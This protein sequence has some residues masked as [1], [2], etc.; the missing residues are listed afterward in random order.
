MRRP[1]AERAPEHVSPGEVESMQSTID[2]LAR[3]DN[4]SS[5]L[6]RRARPEVRLGVLRDRATAV[7]RA[8]SADLEGLADET[9]LLAV[10]PGKWLR[11]FCRRWVLINRRRAA[12]IAEEPG[13]PL[14][15]VPHDPAYEQLRASVCEEFD[16]V[17][18][19]RAFER[20]AHERDGCPLYSDCL[21]RAAARNAACLPC[22]R[23]GCVME[24]R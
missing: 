24:G 23:K 11:E 5:R 8:V 15:P 12:R 16:S 3:Y 21:N 20:R 2:A 14:P 9:L 17:A 22:G 7:G 10:R 6:G 18:E 1:V 13:V 4:A 19:R